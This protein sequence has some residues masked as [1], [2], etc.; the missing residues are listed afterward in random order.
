MAATNYTVR[1]EFKDFR[2][3]IHFKKGQ[4]FA[5]DSAQQDT[6]DYLADGK[7]V[8][9]ESPP[10]N[11]AIDMDAAPYPATRFTGT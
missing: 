3:N 1:R 10:A 8:P 9:L 5:G 2:R 7:I 6:I 4:V 11:V